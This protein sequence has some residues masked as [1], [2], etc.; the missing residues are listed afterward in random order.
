MTAREL[1]TVIV[2]GLCVA[3]LF[4]IGI[5]MMVERNDL[6]RVTRSTIGAV[7]VGAAAIMGGLL[8]FLM[9]GRL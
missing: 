2:L 1:F 9:T 3:A 7:F 5:S 8:Y 4:I 6:R